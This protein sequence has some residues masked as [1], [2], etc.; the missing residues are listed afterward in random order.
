MLTNI[1]TLLLGA[2]IGFVASILTTVLNHKLEKVRNSQKHKW[3]LEEK[4]QALRRDIKN[5]R[6]DE[7]EDYIKGRYETYCQINDLESN[8]LFGFETDSTHTDEFIY[9]EKDNLRKL[10]TVFLVDDIELHKKIDKLQGLLIQEVNN[11]E[12]IDN[13][14]KEDKLDKIKERELTKKNRDEIGQTYANI[15]TIIDA[16]RN[17]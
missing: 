13:E 1:Q 7:L 9:N 8:I 12:R 2:F 15:L 16:L 4:A 3:E 17:K 10:H 6:L 11:Y 14:N 5:K